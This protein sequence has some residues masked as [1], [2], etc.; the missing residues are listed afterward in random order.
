METAA[1]QGSLLAEDGPGHDHGFSHLERFDLADGAWLERRTGWV[2]GADELYAKVRD[3]MA[4]EQGT[5]VIHGKQLLQPR[6]T[7]HVPVD[8]MPIGL[9]IFTRLGTVLSTRYGVVFERIGINWYRDGRDSVAWHGDRIARDRR[10]ATIAIVSLGEARPFRYR[11][12]AGGPS[13]SFRLGHGDL[14]VMG[15]SF[16]RTWRHAVPKVAAAGPRISVTYRH[17][18]PPRRP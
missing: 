15:G 1:W 11:P 10:E 6:L 4:W 13:G 17:A 18:Y 3:R 9:E 12:A 16:Q 14:L 5:E 2:T 7:A 8:A